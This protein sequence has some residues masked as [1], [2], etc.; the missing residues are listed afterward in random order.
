MDSGVGGGDLE[1]ICGDAPVPHP[2]GVGSTLAPWPWGPASSAADRVVAEPG[3]GGGVEG[4]GETGVPVPTRTPIMLLLLAMAVAAAAS[5][6][7]VGS[8]PSHIITQS[9]CHTGRLTLNYGKFG[10]HMTQLGI[11][12]CIL[13]V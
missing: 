7:S 3:L 8:G 5:G 11:R 13:K 6:V 9:A 2:T 4:H 12:I 1:W 10:P